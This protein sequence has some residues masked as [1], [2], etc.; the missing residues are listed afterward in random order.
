[1]VSLDPDAQHGDGEQVLGGD[2]ADGFRPVTCGVP[3]FCMPCEL[4]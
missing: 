1:V 4:R 2:H 3:E